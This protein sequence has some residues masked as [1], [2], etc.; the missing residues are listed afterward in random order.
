MSSLRTSCT[1]VARHVHWPAST[2]RLGGPRRGGG[3]GAGGRGVPGGGGG[4]GGGG[5]A[6]DLGGG[7][8]VMGGGVDALN[9][10]AVELR[11]EGDAAAPRLAAEDGGVVAE[12]ASRQ[13]VFLDRRIEGLD[14]VG[15]LDGSDGDRSQAEAGGGVGGIPGLDPGGG[16]EG[17]LGSDF[18]PAW[19]GSCG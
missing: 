17:P 7:R 4:G 3:E 10:Q 2:E 14:R 18:P 12:E 8:G 5:G 6:L 16:P 1:P 11:F 19:C 13:A 15:G 9:A